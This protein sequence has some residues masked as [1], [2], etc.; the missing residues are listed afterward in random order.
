MSE[1]M[2]RVTLIGNLGSEPELRHTGGGLAVLNLN[3]ATNESYLD[4]DKE[5]KERTEWHTVVVFGARAEAL[6]KHVH[7]GS[8]LCVEGALRTTTYE[9]N[10]MKRMKTEIIAKE[11]VFM[12]PKMPGIGATPEDLALPP[13]AAGEAVPSRTTAKNGKPRAASAKAEPDFDDIPF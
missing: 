3:L 6:V 4:K 13:L 7:K 9:T 5:R 10:G 8:R 12:D 1:G 11:V 2:N